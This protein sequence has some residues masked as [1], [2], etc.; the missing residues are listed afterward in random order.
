M[1]GVPPSI[2]VVGCLCVWCRVFNSPNHTTSSHK[3][4]VRGHHPLSG[5]AW[6]NTLKHMGADD[7]VGNYWQRVYWRHPSWIR[8]FSQKKQGEK[9]ERLSVDG[10]HFLMKVFRCLTAHGFVFAL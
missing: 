1:V 6:P 2:L 4:L 10:L 7:Q 3:C 8:G 9:R 5:M